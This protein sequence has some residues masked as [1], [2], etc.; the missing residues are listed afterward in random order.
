MVA[1]SGGMDDLKYRF[2]CSSNC[3]L[4]S[5]AV[6]DEAEF[7]LVGGDPVLKTGGFHCDQVRQLSIP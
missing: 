5:V 1:S 7:R 3:E 4:R 6:H 2:K